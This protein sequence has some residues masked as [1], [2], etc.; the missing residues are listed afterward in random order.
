MPHAG[1]AWFHTFRVFKHPHHSPRS[2]SRPELL[3]LTWD[4]ISSLTDPD[5]AKRA[6]PILALAHPF[7]VKV[8]P[9]AKVH[10][11]DGLISF[12]ADAAAAAIL[13]IR[14]AEDGMAEGDRADAH[15]G[16]DCCIC[17][18]AR[19]GGA[20]ALAEDMLQAAPR[21]NS[22]TELSFVDENGTR[23]PAGQLLDRFFET[24]GEAPAALLCMVEPGCAM[25]PVSGELSAS[26]E[27]RFEA[28]G[29][30]LGYAA[31]RRAHVRL[32]LSLPLFVYLTTS[33]GKDPTPQCASEAIALLASVA[34]A[35]AHRLRRILAKRWGLT[36]AP[37]PPA[38]AACFGDPAHPASQQPPTGVQPTLVAPLAALK[39][40][41]V[42]RAIS[43]ATK[44]ARVV[45]AVGALLF[46]S[47]ASS[48]GA[49]RRGMDSF[50]G[51][52][53]LEELSAE[54]LALRLVGS[55]PLPPMQLTPQPRVPCSF[56]FHGPDW[57]EPTFLST[58]K[59]WLGTYANKLAAAASHP[60]I[61]I[62]APS[63]Y[64]RLLL[65]LFGCMTG[66]PLVSRGPICV[67]PGSSD[68][69]ELVIDAGQLFL[70][71]ASSQDEFNERMDKSI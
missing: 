46:D 2:A 8:H 61:H 54:A 14:A 69:A 25:L 27:A 55:E 24:V 20:K 34:P 12:A 44:E 6:T 41:V 47:R 42:P 31:L 71:A 43:D 3:D 70:P 29:R 64:A 9:H 66:S 4:L 50:L 40:V 23:R 1:R 39:P 17:V 67:L 35:T 10:P 18:R 51:G 15:T 57:D 59:T 45:A 48:L 49:L 16:N 26:D 32:P 5:P 33:T 58:Y 53:L 13:A 19:G 36:P 63:T 56:T 22:V 28:L 7:F 60:V 38:L 30:I 52:K 65:R 62:G 11:Q 37:L 68:R 21:M